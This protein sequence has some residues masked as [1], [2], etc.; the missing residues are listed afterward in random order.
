MA[1]YTAISAGCQSRFPAARK[2]NAMENDCR[3]E[4]INFEYLTGAAPGEFLLFRQLRRWRN[5]MERKKTGRRKEPV[6]YVVERVYAGTE[7]MERLLT[8]VSEEAARRNVEEKLKNGG[9]E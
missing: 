7:S 2:E 3:M 9:K 8:S 5:Y 1:F 4:L 6:R